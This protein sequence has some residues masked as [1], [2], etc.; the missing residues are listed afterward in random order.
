MIKTETV[1]LGLES[2][3][4]QSGCGAGALGFQRSGHGTETTDL[5]HSLLDLGYLS[6]VGER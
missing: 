5:V 2:D 1:G 3:E 6:T 4:S